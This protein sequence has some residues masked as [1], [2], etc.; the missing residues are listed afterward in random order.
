VVLAAPL[1]RWLLQPG[2]R[3][4]LGVL[5]FLPALWLV[6]AAAMDQLGANPAQVLIRQTGDMALRMLCITLAITPLRH[7]L[8]LSALVRYRRTLGLTMCFYAL[9]HATC[10]AWFDMG[11]D[12]PDIAADIAKR[13]FILVGFLAWLLLLPMAATSVNLAVR[14][15]GVA[16]WQMLHRSVYAV[17]L[18]AI[19]HFFWMRSAKNDFAD[20]AIYGGILALLLGWRVLRWQKNRLK[21]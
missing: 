8:G 7:M 18:L 11:W 21:N 4:A 14:A 15:M 17:A 6:W 3:V 10:Y 12:L 5:G 13:P 9:A 1:N 20:V 2:V 19:L 16:R